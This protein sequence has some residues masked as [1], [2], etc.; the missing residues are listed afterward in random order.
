MIGSHSVLVWKASACTGNPCPGITATC[1][2][3]NEVEVGAEKYVSVPQPYP[4]RGSLGL[5]HG[6]KATCTEVEAPDTKETAA[7]FG[8]RVS[9]GLGVEGKRVHGPTMPGITATYARPESLEG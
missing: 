4:G 9:L 2:R 7:G 6:I 3:V 5:R 8:I 1:T